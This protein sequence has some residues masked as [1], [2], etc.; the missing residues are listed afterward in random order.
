[1]FKDINKEQTAKQAMQNLKH[2]GVA[3]VYVAKF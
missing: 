2:K 1:M 3:T